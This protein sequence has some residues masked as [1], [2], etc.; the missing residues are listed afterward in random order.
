MT[1]VMSSAVVSYMRVYL[2]YE[3]LMVGKGGRYE[4]RSRFWFMH[5]GAGTS[6]HEPWITNEST[7][8]SM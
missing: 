8:G 3:R 2:T 6:D 1:V 5:C 4:G 7:H